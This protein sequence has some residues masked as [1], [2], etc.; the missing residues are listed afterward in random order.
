MAQERSGGRRDIG[1]E[2]PGIVRLVFDL[3]PG[4]VLVRG[5]DE[6][7]ASVEFRRAR[8]TARLLPLQ[9]A[10]WGDT[11][12]QAVIQCMGA[13]DQPFGQYGCRHLR[14]A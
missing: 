13:M 11:N 4:F 3:A 1:T 7:A 10:G 2:A 12:H 5:V 14:D 8:L 9:R 6:E